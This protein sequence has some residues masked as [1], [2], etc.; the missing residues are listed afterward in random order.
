MQLRRCFSA[1]PEDAVHSTQRE[2]CVQRQGLKSK[3][4]GTWW[5]G[6]QVSWQLK[7]RPEAGGA[8]AQIV[9][10]SSRAALSEGWRLSWL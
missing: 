6:K 8:A 1:F 4:V 9:R 10:A 7:E 5:V 2:Q 3:V